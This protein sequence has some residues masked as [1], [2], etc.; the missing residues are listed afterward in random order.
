MLKTANK[1]NQRLY[2][3]IVVP[4]GLC[5]ITTTFIMV[6]SGILHPCISFFVMMY[7][8]DIFVFTET[9]KYHLMHLRK[10]FE[11]MKAIQRTLNWKKC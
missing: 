8:D 1:S 9:W 6:I 5:N 3:W 4:I 10:N 7:L 2:K 11:T